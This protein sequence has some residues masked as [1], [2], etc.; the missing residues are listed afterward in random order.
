M[1]YFKNKHDKAQFDNIVIALHQFKL[2]S[3]QK[4]EK[5]ELIHQ[6][7]IQM[8]NDL[9]KIIAEYALGTITSCLY[10]YYGLGCEEEILVLNCH[11]QIHS[12]SSELSWQ[13]RVGMT[14]ASD[15]D[16]EKYLDDINGTKQYYWRVV[17]WEYNHSMQC[18]TN[19]VGFFNVAATIAAQQYHLQ[20]RQLWYHVLV[21]ENKYAVGIPN[22]EIVDQYH[23]VGELQVRMEHANFDVALNVANQV[24]LHVLK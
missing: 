11:Q 9:F 18:V 13:W 6:I 21:V 17:K 5:T 23:V 16:L 2:E 20:I 4:H 24:V 8:E 22:V 7:M 12:K 1:A 14:S 10:Q 3:T 19:T 15:W